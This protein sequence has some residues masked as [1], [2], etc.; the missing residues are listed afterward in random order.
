MVPPTEGDAATL[1][2]MKQGAVYRVDMTRPRSLKHNGMAFAFFSLLAK[3]LNKG[4]TREQ[5][6][7]D[8]VRRR[9]LIALGYAEVFKVPARMAE[10]YGT[11]VAIVPRSMSF[12]NMDQDEFGRFVDQSL[13]YVV[14]EFGDWLYQAE[15]WKAVLDIVEH[16]QGG[17]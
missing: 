17:Y 12:E 4:P 13:E 9:L 10:H 6:D 5:W 16:A 1:A 11:P 2:E 14:Q 15:E 8:K 7:Q 3:A